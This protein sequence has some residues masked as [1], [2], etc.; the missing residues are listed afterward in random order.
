MAKKE[1]NTYF[2]AFAK[3]ISY[4][5]DAAVLL[6]EIFENFSITNSRFFLDKMH[7]IEHAADKVKHEMM[8]RLA[9]EFLPPIEREDIVELAHTIDEVCD[10]IEEVVLRIYMY[11]ISELRP[12]VQ[13]F[14]KLIVRC[15]A[16]LKEMSLE[17]PNY[18]KSA[19]LT[20]KIR[21][22]NSLEEEGDR[23]YV[24]TTHRLYSEETNP[25]SV[26][27]WTHIYDRLEKCCDGCEK[28]ADT[29]ELIVLK[30]S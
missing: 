22:I 23:L 18:R 1:N 10:L 14:A 29:V 27:A 21:E 12:D 25:I 4:A 11:H 8:E 5:N 3:S 19:T 2:E 17:L 7:K 20:E 6:Q 16:N 24:E 9:K 15:C 30:N 26:F 28:V 13:D